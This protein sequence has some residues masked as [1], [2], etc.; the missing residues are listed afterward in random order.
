MTLDE[1]NGLPTSKA[2]EL[3]TQ[4]CAAER[5][6]AQ[7]IA[8]RPYLHKTD[9]LETAQAIWQTMAEPDYLQAFLAHPQIGDVH[10]LRKKFANT[11]TLA[12]GEQALVS[13][14]STATLTT[15]AEKNTAYLKKFGFIFI[16]F[17]TGKSADEMLA[18]LDERLPHSRE[19]ELLIAAQEQFKITH[20]RLNH[21]LNA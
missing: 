6:V 2:I 15:L 1:F 11:K 17:A 16:V 19:E 4:C 20:L 5:W 14:A 12:A 9:F 18:L 3:I 13:E 8:Q 21:L 10:S 7:F